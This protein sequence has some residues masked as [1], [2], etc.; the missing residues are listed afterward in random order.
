MRDFL[1]DR[2]YFLS[3]MPLSGPTDFIVR[4]VEPYGPSDMV[5]WNVLKV[6]FGPVRINQ[7]AKKLDLWSKKRENADF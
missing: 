6:C 3:T 7:P 4:Y 5:I 1:E 2:A